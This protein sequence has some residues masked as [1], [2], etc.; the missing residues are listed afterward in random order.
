M[1]KV[2]KADR[3]LKALAS[4]D[5]DLFKQVAEPTDLCDQRSLSLLLHDAVQIPRQLG[6]VASFGGSSNIEPSIRSCFQHGQNKP[7]IDVEHFVE[8]MRLEPHSMVWLPVRH[9]VAAAETAKHQ[10]KCN[11]CKEYP[12][13]GFREKSL[14]SAVNVLHGEL[15]NTNQSHTITI[16]LPL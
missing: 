9:R 2:L 7:E 5:D 4:C 3:K 15:L 12:I 16:T 14:E 10:A 11:I 1:D 13:V 6:E 8:W